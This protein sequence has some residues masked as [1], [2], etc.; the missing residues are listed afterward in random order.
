MKNE[1]FLESN[2]IEETG[3]ITRQIIEQYLTS[4]GDYSLKDLNLTLHRRD[5]TN[6]PENCFYKP[7][8]GLILQ[9]EKR[10]VIGN[11]EYRYGANVCIVTGVDM[12]SINYITKASAKKPYLVIS[13][14]L[15]I[16]LLSQL[17]THTPVNY[18]AVDGNSV[19]APIDIDV[20]KAFL[21]LLELRENKEQILILAPMIKS[22]I[23]IRLLNGQHGNLLRS[24]CTSGTPNNHIARAI[25]LLRN[26]YKDTLHVDTIA[27]Q[28][29]MSS[30]S[31]RKHFKAVT[32]MSPTEYHK[33][34]RL[35][36]A[37]RLM[38]ED[39]LNVTHACHSVGFENPTQ[40][41]REYIKLFGESP[42]KNVNSLS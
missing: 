27:S 41:Y 9:G 23:Y 3:R 18:D 19:I 28:V 36:E 11:E 21:R 33:R 14:Y 42:K 12:P 10:T 13:H 31:F 37:Q 32:S 15:D 16:H 39:S 24:L 5:K 25:S 34:L 40:F 20:L 35:Y 6:I 29:H 2:E 22:E 4:E 30:S 17:I 7:I 26:N 8:I 1:N 38:L